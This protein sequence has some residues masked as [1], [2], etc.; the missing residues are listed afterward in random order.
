MASFDLPDLRARE[1]ATIIALADYGSFVAA[2]A[3]MKTSQPALTRTV[4]RVERVLGVTLFTRSTRRVEITEAGREFV[5]VAARVLSDLQ[6]SVRSLHGAPDDQPGQLTISTFSAFSFRTLPDLVHRYRHARPGV[7]V[8]VREGR[9][10][11]VIDDVRSGVADFGVSYVDALPDNLSAEALTR[12]PI[13]ALIPTGHPLSRPKRLRLLDLRDVDLVGPP[14]GTFL[15][16]IIDVP[17]AERG[18]V[19]RYTTLVDR[20]ISIVAY[21]RAGA[22]IG[23]V[24]ASVLPPR[25]WKGFEVVELADPPITVSVGLI[26]LP[27]RYLTPAV[28]D[29][30]NLIRDAAKGT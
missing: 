28:H 7:V 29:M 1:L 5:A 3:H 9:Q 20:L 18:L 19:L 21:V 8:R 4:K 17:A 10:T 27:G 24:P 2:A 6:L 26:T 23:L 16:R 11:D 14:A 13:C 22:G 30:V 15:R 12:E 25:P